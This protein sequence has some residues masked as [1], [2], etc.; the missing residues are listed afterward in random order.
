MRAIITCV[1]YDDFL[2][3]TL[4]RTLAAFEK[5]FVVTSLTD[6]ATMRYVNEQRDRN[7]ALNCWPTN[8]FLS[9]DLSMNKG[10]A[11]DEVIGTVKHNYPGW[12][13][14]L[15]ADIVLPETMDLSGIERGCLYSPRRRM[16]TDPGPIPPEDQWGELLQP[17][18]TCRRGMERHGHQ[19]QRPD[20]RRCRDV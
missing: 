4:S 13:C 6:I 3:I 5:V 16:M 20:G 19:R 15:D 8:A 14:V 12:V 7:M 2:R 11:L 10:A 9:P 18:R 17:W 1:D